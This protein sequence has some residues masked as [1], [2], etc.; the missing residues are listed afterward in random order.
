[1]GRLVL[2]MQA[3]DAVI[4]TVP[5][6]DKP[7]IIEIF[8]PYYL[9]KFNPEQ[10]SV[11]FEADRSIQIVRSQRQ[12]DGSKM[13]HAFGRTFGRTFAKSATSRVSNPSQLEEHGGSCYDDSLAPYNH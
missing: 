9:N 13:E 4:I 5:P 12:P 11:A 8:R 3:R 6:S 10:C 1:M 2:G 7:Q